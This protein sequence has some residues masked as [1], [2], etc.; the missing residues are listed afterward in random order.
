M[1]VV[2]RGDVVE[3][4]PYREVDKHFAEALDQAAETGVEVR[5]YRCR[6]TLQELTIERSILV[7]LC[8]A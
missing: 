4:A 2:Q 7:R 8:V 1:F 3:M 5:A 6:V